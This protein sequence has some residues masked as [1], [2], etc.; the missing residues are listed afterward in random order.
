MR[1]EPGQRSPSFRSGPGVVTAFACAVLIVLIGLWQMSRAWDAAM[2]GARDDVANISRSMAQHA[3]GLL[4]GIEM[5][6]AG[7]AERVGSEDRAALSHYVRRRAE[8]TAHIRYFAVLDPDGHW[9]ADSRDPEAGRAPEAG[10]DDLRWHRDHPGTDLHVGSP[11]PDRGRA[12]PIIPISR[13]LTR[14]DGSFGGIALAALDPKVLQ[15]VYD[16]VRLGS[17]SAIA[18]WHEDGRLLVRR[19]AVA[20]TDRNFADTDYFRALTA[21]GRSTDR[22]SVV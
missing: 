19:P 9:L 15:D 2:N 17:N 10:R 6:L 8:G 3:T 11:R 16:G 13:R 5:A 20:S 22:K 4:D 7:M 12:G 14:P 21:G 18:L 1:T